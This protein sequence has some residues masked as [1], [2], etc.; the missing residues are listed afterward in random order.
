V[1][2]FANGAE[3]HAY[4]MA[5]CSKCTHYKDG[6]NGEC[7]PV[8]MLHILWNYEQFK[9]TDRAMALDLF[10]RYDGTISKECEM[11]VDSMPPGSALD[12]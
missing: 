3:G 10:I 9:N 6:E 4:E 2:Y 1:G 12:E 5:Y 7:C 8:W 11:F